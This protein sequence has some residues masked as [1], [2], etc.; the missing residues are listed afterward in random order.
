[1]LTFLAVVVGWVFFRAS[2]LDAAVQMLESMFAFRGAHVS[3]FY[4]SVIAD[5]PFGRWLELGLLHPRPELLLL[6]TLAIPTIIAF[7]APNTQEIMGHY[8][9]RPRHTAYPVETGRPA[10]WAPRR[11][12][13]ALV[14]LAATWACLGLTQVSEFLYFQF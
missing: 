12:W 2:N 7:V 5:S 11:T 14:A 4:A 8:Y 9:W 6:A 3:P 10:L 1:L 13:A